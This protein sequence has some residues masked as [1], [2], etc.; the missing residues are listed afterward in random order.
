MQENHL[1]AEVHYWVRA[2]QLRLE[3]GQKG[4]RRSGQP[5]AEPTQAAGVANRQIHS[6]N[7]CPSLK[8]KLIHQWHWNQKG[9]SELKG[10]WAPRICVWLLRSEAGS[11]PALIALVPAQ[12]HTEERRKWHK[13]QL[14]RVPEKGFSC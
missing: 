2:A 12:P 14:S 6:W 7:S 10:R 9:R 5:F 11:S 3:K 8:F 13:K 1:L 4:T